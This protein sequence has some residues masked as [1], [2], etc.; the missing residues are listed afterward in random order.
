MAKGKM[1]PCHQEKPCALS[2]TLIVHTNFSL[3]LTETEI[4][5]FV[6]NITPHPI[7]FHSEWVWNVYSVPRGSVTVTGHEKSPDA[8]IAQHC[9]VQFLY[10]TP[11]KAANPQSHTTRS[12]FQMT[13]LFYC[14]QQ[15]NCAEARAGGKVL[16]MA[17]FAAPSNTRGSAA[18]DCESPLIYFGA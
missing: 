3:E 17:P 16:H 11:R 9:R 12:G 5:C 13:S 18:R 8:Y 15:S 1:S 10:N 6:Q 2:S 7:C 4:F 14:L